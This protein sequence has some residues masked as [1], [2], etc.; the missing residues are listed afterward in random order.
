MIYKNADAYITISFQDN[1]PS[2]VL[3]AMASGLPILYSDSGGV[4]ELVGENSGIGLKVLEN[5]EKTQFPNTYAIQKGM[6]EII[7]NKTKMSK[8]SRKRAV[9]KFDIKKWVKK[10]ELIFEKLLKK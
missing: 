5:W 7:N 3:E 1:C 8:A 2:A 9:E 6:R 4:P 10:Q